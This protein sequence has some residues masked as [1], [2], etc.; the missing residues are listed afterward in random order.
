MVASRFLYMLPI[1]IVYN[2][3]D[4]SW[5]QGNEL[6]NLGQYADAATKYKLVSFEHQASI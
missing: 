4:F 1:S 6:H 2:P 3:F 5:L